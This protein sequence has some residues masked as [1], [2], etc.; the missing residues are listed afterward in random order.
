MSKIKD[1]FISSYNEI[2]NVRCITLV[3]MFGAISIVLGYLAIMPVETI[4]IT[5]TFLPNEFVFYL[6]GPVVGAVYGAALDILTW[7]IKPAGPFFYGFTVS[8]VLTGL[9]YGFILYKRPLS[10]KR[11]IIANLIYMCTVNLLLNT[12]WLTQLYG[13]SFMALLPMRALKAVI[14]FPVETAMLYALIKGV[15]A[16]GVLKSLHNKKTKVS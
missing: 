5:F 6:F 9:L 8:A 4:K 13:Y 14:M 16:T 2:K 10:L 7:F 15:E 12:Y 3:A 1:L 11:I